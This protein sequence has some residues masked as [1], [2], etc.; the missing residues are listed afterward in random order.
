M[1]LAGQAALLRVLQE[2]AFERRQLGHSVDVRV[3]STNTDLAKAVAEGG[4]R[5]DL[6]RLNVFGIAVPPLRER[7]ED[8][9]LLSRHFLERCNQTLGKRPGSRARHARRSRARMA[10][11][12]AEL[13]NARSSWNRARSS[14]P[15]PASDDFAPGVEVAPTR[16]AASSDCERG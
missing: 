5:A 13:E 16:R 1:P 8:I 12:R 6:Y 15:R 9:P 4:F 11:Q 7:V 14:C 3:A 10:G 2:H